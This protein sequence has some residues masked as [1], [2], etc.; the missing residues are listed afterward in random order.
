VAALRNEWETARQA[1]QEAVLQ[2]RAAVLADLDSNRQTREQAATVSR[3]TLADHYASVQA[4]TNL[5]LAQVAQQR[6][7]MAAQTAAQ[8]EAF[9][10]E[11]RT[12]VADQRADH[13]EA[14]LDVAAQVA[15]LQL[16]TQ[17][18]L[19]GYQRDRA[20]VRSR[21]QQSLAEYVAELAETVADS[22]TVLAED[23][24]AMA[25]VN[26]A[27][28]HRDRAALTA[29][30]EVMRD[31]WADY[32]QQLREFRANLRQIVWGDAVPS[33]AAPAAPSASP[34]NHKAPTRKPRAKAKA[35]SA[36][37][38]PTKTAAAA[39]NVAQATAPAEK[40]PAAP[41]AAVPTEEAV[42]DYL[43]AHNDG[44]RLTE[45]EATLG[46]NRFQAVDALRSLIQKELIV[47]KDRTYRI[48]EEAVL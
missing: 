16:A 6:Q 40:K 30:V 24:Q 8:L 21:Q 12:F 29:E 42:F 9:T 26:Q 5:Y 13:Q 11:L 10:A 7:T 31:D 47:Q 44:A 4:E 48:Q 25:V 32:R 27:E 34:A 45:I 14:M 46:I 17:E 33:T 22:L 37:A 38:V 28:R 15:D 23:R 41:K 3:Q 35:A 39:T 19:A 20:V 1:R 43:Q 2:R 18:L 36:K